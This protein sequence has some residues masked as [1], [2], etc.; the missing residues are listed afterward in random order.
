[1]CLALYKMMAIFALDTAHVKT[2]PHSSTQKINLFWQSIQDV[3]RQ[4]HSGKLRRRLSL[5]MSGIGSNLMARDKNWVSGYFG[6]LE[7]FWEDFFETFFLHQK[8]VP[9][10]KCQATV[11]IKS[12][13]TICKLS[14]MNKESNTS[15]QTNGQEV[16]SKKMQNQKRSVEVIFKKWKQISYQRKVSGH[17]RLFQTS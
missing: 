13:W 8:N 1:M 15:S 17:C 12:F 14:G 7:Q 16:F 3:A 10:D 11:T 4:F 6:P 2:Y 5:I 9:S